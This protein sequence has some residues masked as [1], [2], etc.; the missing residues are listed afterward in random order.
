LKEPAIVDRAISLKEPQEN[1][2]LDAQGESSVAIERSKPILGISRI[3]AHRKAWEQVVDFTKIR[4][5]GVAI[6]D[7]INRL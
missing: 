7:L 4:K 6:E 5:S 1:V 3:G 2:S